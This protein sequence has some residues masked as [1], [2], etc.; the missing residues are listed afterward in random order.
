MTIAQAFNLAFE[1]W[2]ESQ[3]KKKDALCVNGNCLNNSIENDSDEVSVKHKF[4]EATCQKEK[5]FTGQNFGENFEKD[6]NLLID[7]NSPADT[8]DVKT[9]KDFLIKIETEE[10]EDMDANFSK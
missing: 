4:S 8:L 1:S 3:E 2:K 10:T 6:E 9:P 7:L 5:D